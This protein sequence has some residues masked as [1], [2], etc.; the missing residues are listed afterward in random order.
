MGVWYLIRW[1]PIMDIYLIA[2][3]YNSSQLV[4]IYIVVAGVTD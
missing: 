1:W 2:S 4:L 3:K